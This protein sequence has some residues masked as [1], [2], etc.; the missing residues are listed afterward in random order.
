MEKEILRIIMESPLCRNMTEQ[1][2][3]IFVNKYKNQVIHFAAGEYVFSELMKPEKIFV[4]LSG[5]VL[6]AR[7]TLSGK[8]MLLSQI[9]CPGELFGEVYAFMDKP[10]YDMYAETQKAADVLCLPKSFF[11]TDREETEEVQNEIKI[12][13]QQ[14]LLSV[15]AAK[16]YSLNQK[17]RITSSASLREKIA[18]F[19]IERQD[20]KG[21][22]T[23]TMNRE[24]MADYVNVARPSL[25]RELGKMADE[26][27]LAIENR[28]IIVKNQKK[29]EEYL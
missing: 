6:I 7:N 11:Y 23:G 25:S 1:E 26:G 5:K 15:F 19:I 17:L 13:L 3:Q 4:L 18:H 20:E 2:C 16:A 24:Q 14:N 9:D 8:R 12:K 27:L 28:K 29:L 21:N 22:L 10:Q